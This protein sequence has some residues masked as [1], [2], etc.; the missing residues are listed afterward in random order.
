[1]DANLQALM[2]NMSFTGA[3]KAA[4]LDVAHFDD[5][6][7]A[8]DVKYGLVGKVLSPRLINDT[9]FI[10]V[11]SNI[12]AEEKVEIMD[13]KPG[14]FLFKVPSEMHLRN[15]VKRG[16]WFVDGESI[17]ITM[18]RPSL[19]LDEYNFDKMC[20]WIRVYGLP[21]DKMT[22]V[23][24]RK[25]GECFGALDYVDGRQ[26]GGNLG[27]YFR[28]KVELTVTNP[29]LRVVMLPNSND[30]PRACPIQYE[31]LNKFCFY[32]GV[33]GHEVELC[34]KEMPQGVALPYGPW[35][36]VPIETRMPQQRV[37]R[38]I[39]AVRD[40]EV[41]THDRDTPTLPALADAPS[42]STIAPHIPC[43]R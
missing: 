5:I 39:I 3:E 10:C 2:A 18:F 7:M 37:C 20:W 30:K 24:A 23:T 4:L 41:L 11:F 13:L 31:K 16:P 21:L 38:G 33:L 15:V 35:L 26:I 8:A 14:V 43:K 29:L 19:S 9:T 12:M 36:R 1:M 6:S 28:L 27:D 17:A 40:I 42:F 34:S 32:C 25:I 22:M